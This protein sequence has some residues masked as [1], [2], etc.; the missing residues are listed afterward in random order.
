MGYSELME[1]PKAGELSKKQKEFNDAI[2]RSCKTLDILINNIL[3]NARFEAGEMQ[4]NFYEFSVYELFNEVYEMFHP[5]AN[6]KK[7]RLIPQE[8]KLIAV[9][10][11][12]KIKEVLSNLLGNAIKFVP[13]QGSIMLRGTYEEGKIHISVS[14]TGKGI[15]E[16]E[17]PRLFEKFA[18]ARGEKRGTGLGL[19][20]IK[21]IIE[22]HGQTISVNSTPGRGTL[23]T[24]TLEGREA[25]E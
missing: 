13:E 16:D 18:Q 2:M 24:F 6:Y 19:Y 9:A 5:I 8:N 4:Y 11:R 15:Q 21:K 12:E 10:D 3:M 25:K 22:A 1:S 17:I 7:I 14:D 20:I 23:F